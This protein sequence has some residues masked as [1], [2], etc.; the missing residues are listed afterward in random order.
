MATREMQEKAIL[1]EV[2]SKVIPLEAHNCEQLSFEQLVS[3][4]KSPMARH[5]VN[6]YVYLSTWYNL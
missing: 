3:H 4:H 5:N 1:E 2:S 6:F